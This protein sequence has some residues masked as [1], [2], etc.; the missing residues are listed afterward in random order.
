M[1]T[2]LLLYAGSPV[3]SCPELPRA[4][5][6][7]PTLAQR[8]VNGGPG[9]AGKV[10]QEAKAGRPT[11]VAVEGHP[12]TTPG[13]RDP[14]SMPS[15]T[16]KTPTITSKTASTIALTA[17][18]LTTSPQHSPKRYANDRYSHRWTHYI[19]YNTMAHH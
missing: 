6:N 12:E 5:N 15:N 13:P 10:D 16:V 7:D 18:I 2:I 17:Y 8:G 3:D 11:V 19:L 14:P 1:Q 4:A 9:N